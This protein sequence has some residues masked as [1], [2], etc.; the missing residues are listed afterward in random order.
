[1][2]Y[3]RCVAPMYQATSSYLVLIV[4][5]RT[6]YTNCALCS[7]HHEQAMSKRVLYLGRGHGLKYLGSFTLAAACLVLCAGLT[8]VPV[9]GVWQGA[10]GE[11]YVKSWVVV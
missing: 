5:A 10:L 6:L 3:V 4:V 2:F 7:C 11:F 8:Q 9:G 1:M